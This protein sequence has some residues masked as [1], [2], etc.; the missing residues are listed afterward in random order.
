MSTE[1][2]A[3]RKNKRS[4][5][6]MAIAKAIIDEYQPRNAEEMQDALKDIFGPMFE[7]MLQGEMDSHL[8]TRA[9]TMGINRRITAAMDISTKM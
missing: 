3:P 8:A 7:A 5:A 1:I 6:S 9:M 4:K 2:M